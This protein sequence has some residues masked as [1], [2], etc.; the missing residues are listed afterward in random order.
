MRRLIRRLVRV[1]TVAVLVTAWLAGALG[2]G[3]ATGAGAVP[4][5]AL[6]ALGPLLGGVL[7]L[8]RH[9]LELASRIGNLDV[10]TQRTL[11]SVR[12]VGAGLDKELK[13]E[14]RQTFRQ[15]EALQNLNAMLP[16]SDVLPATRVWAASPDLLVVLVDLVIT[17]RPSLVVEC[18]SGASTLWLALAMRR[19]KIDGRIIALEHDPVFGGKTRDLLARHDVGDLAEVRDAPLESFSLDG[20]TYLWYARRA[21]EDLTGID[22]L[23]VD[24]P[25]ATTGHQARYPALPLLGGSLSPVATAVL[26]DLVVPDMQKVLQLWLDAYPDFS[27]EILPLEKQAAVLRRS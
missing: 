9:N 16:A 3:L 23:F 25:P 12:Q 22:L 21:W 8:I 15:L 26:D 4:T 7:L 20:E 6:M 13:K 24:G 2:L 19:F 17:G 5:V 14:I 11:D 18:G 27:S 1:Q 10:R